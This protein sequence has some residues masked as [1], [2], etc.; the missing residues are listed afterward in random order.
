MTQDKIEQAKVLFYG[1]KKIYPPKADE[2]E[3]WDD[4]GIARQSDFIFLIDALF[5]SLVS[6]AKAAGYA[7]PMYF[8]MPQEQFEAI[9]KELGYVK[10]DEREKVLKEIGEWLERTWH[11]GWTYT[12]AKNYVNQLK[13]GKMPEEK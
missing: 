10:D 2:N 12:M 3:E 7:K 6:K 8:Q 11:P 13:Q 1:F 4:I 5:P 9:A